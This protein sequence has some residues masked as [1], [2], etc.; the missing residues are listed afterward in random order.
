MKITEQ[1]AE[2]LTNCELRSSVV[3]YAI[4]SNNLQ[5]IKNSASSVSKTATE[6]NNMLKLAF[7]EERKFRTQTFWWFF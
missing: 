5:I 4:I 3:V 2:S 7:I 6:T 1:S